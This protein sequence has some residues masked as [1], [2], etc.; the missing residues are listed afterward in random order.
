MAVGIEETNSKMF[1][2]VILA[3]GGL[4]FSINIL[5]PFTGFLANSLWT[6]FSCWRINVH[7]M[8]HCVFKNSKWLITRRYHHTN[9]IAFLP[10]ISAFVVS[11]GDSDFS[12]HLQWTLSYVIHFSLS[13][14]IY[15]RN[16]QLE[17]YISHYN[18]FSKTVITCD[19]IYEKWESEQLKKKN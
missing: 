16:D 1:S 18:W 7:L 12:S 2:C 14:M 11:C 8:F 4:R 6:C 17:W 10:Y 15:V 19:L 13:I 3:V 9:T 5:F